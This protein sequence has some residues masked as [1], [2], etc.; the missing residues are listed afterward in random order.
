MTDTPV[1]DFPQ[2]VN[3]KLVYKG[4][5]AFSQVQIPANAQISPFH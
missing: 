2:R 5:A 4:A 3:T 1:F